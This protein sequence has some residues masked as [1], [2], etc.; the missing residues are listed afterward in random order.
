M[1]FD[2][3]VAIKAW[4]SLLENRR[5]FLD[6]DVDELEAHLRDQIEELVSTGLD[7]TSAFSRSVARIGTVHELEPE[8]DKVRWTKHLHRHSY[9]QEITWEVTMLKNYLVVALRNLRRHKS[10]TIISVAGLAV[11]LACCLFIL[12]FIEHETSYD[13]HHANGDR[14]FRLAKGNSANTPELWAP[15]LEVEFPEVERAVRIKEGFS[16]TLM[17][18]EEF[19][20]LEPHGLF[21]DASAFD[22]FYWPLIQGQP[23]TALAAPFTIVVSEKLAEKY[24][25]DDDPIGRTLTLAG[26]S[27]ASAPQDFQVTGV[28]ADDPNLSH[29]RFDYLVSMATV[30]T[31]NDAGLWGTPLSWTNRMTKTYLLLAK[32]STPDRVESRIPSF[33]RNHISDERYDVNNGRLQALPDIHLYSNLHAEF[34]AGGN[35]GYVYLF[36]ALAMFILLLACINFMNLSTARAEHRAL[37]VG[38]RKVMGAQR[39]QVTKQFLGESMLLS[40]VA[41]FLALGIMVIIRPAFADLTGFELTL[42]SILRGKVIFGFIAVIL[43]VGLLAGSYPAL[44]LS[45]FRPIATLQSGGTLSNRRSIFLRKGLVVFQFVISIALLAGTAIVYKQVQYFQSKNLGFNQEQLA[46]IPVG[47][48]EQ[49]S[50]RWA[51]VLNV[52]TR[53]SNVV[54]GAG[55]HSIPGHF[56]NRFRYRPEGSTQDD[57]ISL[58]SLS[59]AHDFLDLYEVELLAGR[60]FD[61]TISSDSNAFV[62]NESAIRELG[63]TSATDAVGQHLE[64]VFP[65]L[66]FEGPVIGVV[67][68]FHFESLHQAI[69][70]TVFHITRFGVN[71]L[72]LR[73]SSNEVEETR[74][75]LEETW[76]Q[77]EPNYPFD[78]YFFDEHFADQYIAEVRLGRIFTYGALLSVL[79]ACLGLFGLAAFTAESRRKEIG[80]R[81]VLGATVPQI[82]MLLS[83]EYVQIVALAF[84]VA[85]PLAFFGMQRW[86]EQFAYR[87]EIGGLLFIW[88]GL[89][90]FA[91]VLTTVSYQS[92]RAALANPVRTLRHG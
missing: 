38:V 50:D 66:G 33:L 56:L 41:F 78:F 88:I 16:R 76:Q 69:Q 36:S 55:S 79:I 53:H 74:A 39:N 46:I 11:G 24:F 9:W 3:E 29:I 34:D 35:I 15:A 4:R 85:C 54:S 21:A 86:L 7:E 22:V 68:D 26:I 25:G 12:I 84:I 23:S 58:G 61:A 48:S 51:T 17:R 19:Q 71:F 60:G 20:A 92:I 72:T 65:N 14:I 2:L 40:L 13:K 37:E 18:Y 87:I 81:K 64:W 75:Y 82:A 62:L 49:V 27:N 52:M 89:L 32:N 57:A 31:L 45:A 77:F 43:V 10:Y 83:K 28:I 6:E 63:W 42:Q 30:E 59:V 80:V 70:P 91:I 5:A 8:Y 47:A 73:V 1:Q 67:R 44:V 90:A